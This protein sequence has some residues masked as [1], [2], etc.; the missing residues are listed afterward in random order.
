MKKLLLLLFL[1]PNLVMAEL[2]IYNCNPEGYMKGGGYTKGD[3]NVEKSIIKMARDAKECNSNCKKTNQTIKTKINE[4][5]N[6]ILVDR[7]KN[8]IHE[9]STVYESSEPFISSYNNRPMREGD[10]VQI[11]D[12]KN[13]TFKSGRQLIGESGQRTVMLRDG[14]YFSTYDYFGKNY[15]GGYPLQECGK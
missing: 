10:E 4:S 5:T 2:T 9:H 14:K 3:P 11:F 8:G 6:K 15:Y 1:M 13:W 7:Y 12:K